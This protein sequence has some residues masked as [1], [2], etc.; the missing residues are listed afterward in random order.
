MHFIYVLIEAG[1]TE[2]A[3]TESAAG[4]SPSVAQLQNKVNRD[5]QY[6]ATRAQHPAP[7]HH[8]KHASNGNIS[9]DALLL[10]HLFGMLRCYGYT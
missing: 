8:Y 6:L 1:G 7:P 5:Q 3:A 9:K 2:T 4:E 10:R